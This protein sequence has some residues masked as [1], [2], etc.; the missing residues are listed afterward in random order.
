MKK[1]TVIQVEKAS[2]PN[3]RANDDRFYNGTP[4]AYVDIDQNEQTLKS[5]SLF[6]LAKIKKNL[7][8]DLSF[9]SK[10]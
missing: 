10:L 7:D 5:K 8:L 2:T 1:S 9:H 4:S 3:S 6:K